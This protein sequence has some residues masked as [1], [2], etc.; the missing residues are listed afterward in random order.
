M[1]RGG[2]A[3]DLKDPCIKKEVGAYRAALERGE[4]FGLFLL[5]P[6]TRIVGKEWFANLQMDPESLSNPTARP[7]P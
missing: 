2:Y 6:Y 4:T 5:R 1:R 7:R 3:R